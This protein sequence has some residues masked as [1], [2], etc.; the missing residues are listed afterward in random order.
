M[1]GLMVQTRLTAPPIV[2][3]SWSWAL[4]L[5]PN[6]L[7]AMPFSQYWRSLSIG[8]PHHRPLASRPLGTAALRSIASWE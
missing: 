2:S 4:D 3:C 1:D 7:A 6:S 5:V 8:E